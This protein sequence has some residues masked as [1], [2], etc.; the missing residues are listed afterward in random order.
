MNAGGDMLD[1]TVKLRVHPINTLGTNGTDDE[2]AIDDDI[3]I[4]K[5]GN[6]DAVEFPYSADQ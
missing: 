6:A 1:N 4:W 2:D 3:T 5:A